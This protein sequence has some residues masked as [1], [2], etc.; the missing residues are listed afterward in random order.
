M[1]GSE[2]SDGDNDSLEESV[3]CESSHVDTCGFLS[4]SRCNMAIADADALDATIFGRDVISPQ[5]DCEYPQKVDKTLVWILSS[6]VKRPVEEFKTMIYRV[7]DDCLVSVP[8]EAKRRPFTM[9][10]KAYISMGS[11]SGRRHVMASL[12]GQHKGPAPMGGIIMGL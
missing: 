6:D 2:L 5:C 7:P 10:R 8:E 11:S 1:S 9:S 3:P 12:A 4:S